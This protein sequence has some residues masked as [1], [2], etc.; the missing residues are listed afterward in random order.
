MKTLITV[1]VFALSLP[2]LAET[3]LFIEGGLEAH[4]KGRDCPEYCGSNPLGNIGAGYTF[5]PTDRVY[6]DAYVNHMSSIKDTEQGYGQNV[7]GVRGRW[8]LK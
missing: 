3:G 4:S 8:Y 5:K 6:I 7:L 2:A 1:C